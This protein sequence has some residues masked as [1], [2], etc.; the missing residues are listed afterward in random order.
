MHLTD[1]EVEVIGFVSDGVR[2]P[3]KEWATIGFSGVGVLIRGVR[4]DFHFH[5][6]LRC[7]FT[8][9]RSSPTH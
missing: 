9:I 8:C 3:C 7:T 1:F 2:E 6:I 5:T 4:S